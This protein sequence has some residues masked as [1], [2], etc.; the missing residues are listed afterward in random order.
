MRPETGIG[1]SKY[2]K[3]QPYTFCSLVVTV[4]LVL[5]VVNATI[6]RFATSLVLDFPPAKLT[7]RRVLAPR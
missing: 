5:K 7:L 4:L 2:K 6:E 1:L 3:L